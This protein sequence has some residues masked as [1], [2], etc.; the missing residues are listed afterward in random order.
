MR[1]HCNFTP[2]QTLA[3]VIIGITLDVDGNAL[4]QGEAERLAPVAGEFD[5]DGAVG[6]AW[7]RERNEGGKKRMREWENERVG[8]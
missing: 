3:N 7:K 4:G 5:V 6:K 1:K 8:E 2:G